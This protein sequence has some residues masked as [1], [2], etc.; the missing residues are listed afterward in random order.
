MSDTKIHN[1]ILS[2][3]PKKNK[4]SA[5]KV[6]KSKTKIVTIEKPK[7]KV[8]EQSD[9]YLEEQKQLVDKL[10]EEN[11][12]KDEKIK[13]MLKNSLPKNNSVWWDLEGR[14]ILT[15][16]W[17]IFYLYP[18][19]C[20]LGWILSMDLLQLGLALFSAVGIFYHN[21]GRLSTIFNKI[22]E[23]EI[24]VKGIFSA[25]FEFFDS[26]GLFRIHKLNFQRF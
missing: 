26:Y 24:S 12:V 3:G 22:Y 21:K 19:L 15:E 13:N 1:S 10:V 18:L 16:C 14:K 8:A 23:H 11:R 6:K 4:R 17:H 5:K 25:L 9:K 20:C 2:T 7:A